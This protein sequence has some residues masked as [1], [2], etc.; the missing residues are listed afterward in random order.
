LEKQYDVLNC[1][2]KT[3]T[4]LDEG[5]QGGKIQGIPRVVAIR[6]IS[7][8]LL[9]KS[10]RKRCQIFASHMEKKTKDNL[11]STEDHPVLRDDAGAS[12]SHQKEADV[13]L[14]STPQHIEG[15]EPTIN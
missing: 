9:K 5:E 14:E 6:E 3:I 11:A 13:E 1:Y 8:M 4:F 7:S 15:A 10:F 2:K 12:Q